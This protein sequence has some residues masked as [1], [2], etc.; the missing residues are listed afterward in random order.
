ML[1]SINNKKKSFLLE[2]RLCFWGEI[3]IT[4]GS[5][6]YSEGLHSGFFQHFVIKNDD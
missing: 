4:T 5:N 3:G 2:G 6:L 1:Q